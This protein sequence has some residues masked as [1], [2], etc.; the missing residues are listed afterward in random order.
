MISCAGLRLGEVGKGTSDRPV[1]AVGSNRK[2][3]DEHAD[4]AGGDEDC[5]A[6]L[7]G[8]L[9]ELFQADFDAEHGAGFL[10]EHLDAGARS[11]RVGVQ[12]L[13]AQAGFAIGRR[14]NLQ[15]VGPNVG[16]RRPRFC[17]RIIGV[18]D[19]EGSRLGAPRPALSSQNR[20]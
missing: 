16:R 3:L 15:F 12:D 18:G 17:M 10:G 1:P 4:A 20:G 11:G 6:G 7:N 13:G 5:V 19:F 14:A 9:G 8:Q 2:I